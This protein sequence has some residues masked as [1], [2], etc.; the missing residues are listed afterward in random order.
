[1][2]KVINEIYKF[3]KPVVVGT[4]KSKAPYV[5]N[6]FSAETGAKIIKPKTDMKLEEKKQ[7]VIVKTRNSHEF[8]AVASAVFAFKQIKPLF[9]KID[10]KLRGEDKKIIRLVKKTIL[11]EGNISI[12]L[13]VNKIKKNQVLGSQA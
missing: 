6:K 8:D 7:F 10:K 9:D 12:A 4:D 3:G 1:M 13:T 5:I 11:E 2:N